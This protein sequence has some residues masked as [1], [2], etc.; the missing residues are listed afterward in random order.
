MVGPVHVR[1]T[2]IKLLSP[3][4]L[5][6]IYSKNKTQGDKNWSKWLKQY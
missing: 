3:F 2:V 1:F 6:G 5:V 4:S